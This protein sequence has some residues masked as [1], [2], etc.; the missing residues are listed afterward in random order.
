LF[1]NSHHSTVNKGN[2]IKERITGRGDKICTILSII[3]Q[4]QITSIQIETMA[5]FVNASNDTFTA[6][7]LDLKKRVALQLKFYKS[8]PQ[9]AMNAI[10]IQGQLDTMPSMPSMDNFLRSFNRLYQTSEPFRKSLM[11]GLLTAYVAKADGAVNPQYPTRVINFMLALYASGDRKAFQFVSGNLCSISVR[12]IARLTSKKRQAPF[13]DLD[14]DMMVQR[15]QEHIGKVRHHRVQAGL[16]PMSSSREFNCEQ[17]LRIVQKTN[18]K[19]N[20]IFESDLKTQRSND[21]LSG[22]QATFDE[23]V[24]SVKGGWR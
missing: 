10:S 8:M 13:I 9:N 1:P 24:S 5:K 23:Y 16:F 7:G 21:G 12:H 3:G 19:I 20:A 11:V 18:V 22:Y 15:I 2:K 17:L 6:I 4:S 14:D